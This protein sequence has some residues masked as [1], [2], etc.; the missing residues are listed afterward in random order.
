MCYCDYWGKKGLGRG[1]VSLF[2]CGKEV[3]VRGVA[4][5]GAKTKN[6]K[7]CVICEQQKNEA[8]HHFF[9]FLFLM[10]YSERKKK[11]KKET[12]AFFFEVV[13]CRYFGF[14]WDS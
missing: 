6:E 13:S 2:F 10:K 9:F 8:R 11:K 4:L 12:I 3:W 5:Q 14:F 1:V 7:R